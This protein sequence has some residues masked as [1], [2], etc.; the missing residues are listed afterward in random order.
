MKK[1]T[2]LL[3]LI[4]IFSLTA[5]GQTMKNSEKNSTYN[6]LTSAEE[7]VIVHKG[8]EWAYSG[9]YY[10]HHE[11]GVYVCKRCNFPLYRSADKFDSHCGW[12]SFDDE[13]KGAVERVKDADGMRTEIICSNCKGHLGHVFEGEGMTDKDVRHCVNSVSLNF[14]PAEEIVKT[15]TALFASGC[16][17]GTE[18][19]FQKVKGVISTEVGYSGGNKDNPGYKEVSSG[20]TGHAETVQVVFDPSKTS[21]KE[22]AKLF[23]ETHDPGQ[24]NGQGP[25]IGSQYRS[26][27]FYLNEAQKKEAEALVLQLKEKGYSVVT[28]I[29]KAGKFWTAE[30]YHQ[31]YY[32]N[33]GGSPYCHSYVKKF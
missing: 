25:D 16:F 27:I 10:D 8:T 12:P 2:C 11:K 17:W 1:I 6:K 29:T 24:R 18:Y 20:K 28:E 21:Y 15:D 7:K 13:I 32:E 5:C 9:K 30:N 22:L 26:A 31:N 14:I 4:T 19:H 23:F 3:Q 33:T